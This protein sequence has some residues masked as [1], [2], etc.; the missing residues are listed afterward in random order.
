MKRNGL[1]VSLAVQLVIVTLWSGMPF[2]AERETLVIAAS[3]S[4]TAPLRALAEG[5]EQ[6]HPQVHVRLHFD[7]GLKLRGM[8]AGMQNSPSGKFGIEKGPIHLVAPGGDELIARLE[9]KYYVLP[10]TKHEYAEERVVLV[11]PESLVDA[12]N[13]FESL[14]QSKHL[15]VAIADPERTNLGAQTQGILDAYGI[16]GKVALHEA[17]DF[18]GVLDHMLRGDADAGIIYMHQAVKE[19]E[20]VRIAAVADRGY[21][22]I[23]HSMAMERYCPNRAL[24]KDFLAYVQS[25][26]GQQCVRLTGYAAPSG[27]KNLVATPQKE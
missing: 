24:C 4:L 3:P 1:T 19:Q 9:S 8:I 25:S 5:Y 20:R 26:E 21:R 12:P 17:S 10:G 15:R 13:S 14:V 6:T 23:V 22:P 2:A 11:V 18:R 27:I 7:N 16:R